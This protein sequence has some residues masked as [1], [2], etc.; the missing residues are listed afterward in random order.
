MKHWLKIR[1]DLYLQIRQRVESTLGQGSLSFLQYQKEYENSF[2]AAWKLSSKELLLR[3]IEKAKIVLLA[4]FHALQ[5]SQKAHLRI[6]Q[7]LPSKQQGILAVEFFEIRHQKWVDLFLRGELPEKEFLRKVSWNESWGFPWEHYRPMVRW[8][9]KRKWKVIALNDQSQDRSAK[10]LKQRDQKAALVIREV[11]RKEPGT[12]VFVVFGDLH[13]AESHLPSAI[14]KCTGVEKCEMLTI[15]QNSEKIYFQ[16]LKK[17]LEMVVDVV[18]LKKN[19]F[20]LMNVPPWVKWQNYL[21]FLEQNFDSELGD[22]GLDLTDEVVRYLDLLAKDLGFDVSKDHFSIFTAESEAFGSEIQKLLEP[23]EL[24]Y[25]QALIENNVS[26][27]LPQANIAYL[28][29]N[30]VNHAAV[31]AMAVLH[32]EISKTARYPSRLPQD[33]LS[34]IWLEAVLYF[35]SKIINPKRKT[36][37]LLDM[38]SS[39]NTKL[40]LG[41]ERETLQLALQQKMKEIL[42]LSQGRRSKESLRPRKKASY[43]EAARLLGGMLGE[44]L[45]YAYRK[46][47]ISKMTLQNLLRKRLDVESFKNV[48]FEILEMVE[49]LPEP[50]QS[51]REKL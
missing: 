37:T 33:F 5:Q 7:A 25:F 8:A 27:Y 6:L 51:K 35:G 40:V 31:I 22:E 12:Q 32:A 34:L 10:S 28:A 49:L 4:D 23:S 30:S 38:K 24:R 41:V 26:F 19:Q 48:Y 2:R 14:Q 16:L 3:Q 42:F 46:H 43:R 50:F 13:L 1:H 11:V 44:K 17:N 21:L 36:D 29:Q 9:Q 45:Y 18:Q 20:C 15:F 39:L 47:L